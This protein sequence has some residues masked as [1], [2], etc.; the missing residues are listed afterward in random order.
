[1][2]LFVL[3][4]GLKD[5]REEFKELQALT[6]DHTVIPIMHAL[7]L[8]FRENL[9][10]NCELFG[11][12]DARGMGGDGIWVVMDGK[13]ISVGFNLRAIDVHDD[14]ESGWLMRSEVHFDGREEQEEQVK[15]L[16]ERFKRFAGE[17]GLEDLKA[18]AKDYLKG[19]KEIIRRPDIA[20]FYFI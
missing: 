8:Y 7:A 17:I 15:K 10:K 5:L 1:M 13:M 3:K 6:D 12:T 9:Y 14:D 18:V 20:K 11:A 19:D 16:Y 4:Y 2:S